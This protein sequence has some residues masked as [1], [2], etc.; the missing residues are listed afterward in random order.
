M[1]KSRM[2][3]IVVTA[4]IVAIVAFLYS[5]DIK[6]LVKPKEEQAVATSA[7]QAPTI[8]AK[9][10]LKELS[11]VAK[12]LISNASAKDITRLEGQYQSAKGDEKLELAK[13]LAQKWADLEQAAPSAIY[14]N[15]LAEAKPSLKNWINAGD[16]F[17]KAFDTTQDSLIKASVLQKANQAFKQAIAID[18]TSL[19]AKTGLGTTLVSGSAPMEGIT[20]LL[21]V[22]KTE[23]KNV[24]ANMV[25]GMF[26]MQ[27]GQFDK[28]V[29]R[30]QTVIETKATPDAYFYLATAYENL[31][32]N[33]EAIAAFQKSKQLAANPSLSSFIDKK[34]A[35]LKTK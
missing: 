17:V 32:K 16:M 25:L 23:P 9:L 30:F 18:S 33:T 8:T 5:K 3:Q 13:T 21:G 35:E 24:K 7:R 22:V 20:M 27:S 34:V 26:A 10:D 15:E 1:E 28:A 6:G 19:D 14:W 12:N 31:G 2:I 29:S 11:T 4:G